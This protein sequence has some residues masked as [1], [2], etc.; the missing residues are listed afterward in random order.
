MNAFI[1]HTDKEQYTGLK[2][3]NGRE[4]IYAD[5]VVLTP[6]GRVWQV[7]WNDFYVAWVLW[8][9]KDTTHFISLPIE[10]GKLHAFKQGNIHENLELLK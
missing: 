8:S 1:P 3:K 6:N 7:G 5:D 4:D 10:D 9:L 2:D